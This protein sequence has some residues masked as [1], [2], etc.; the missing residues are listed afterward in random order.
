M[1]LLKYLYL[2]FI[3]VIVFYFYVFYGPQQKGHA[4][5]I[6]HKFNAEI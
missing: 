6:V 3:I 5:F 1:G 2:S 4:L